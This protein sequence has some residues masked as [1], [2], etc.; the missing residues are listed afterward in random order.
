MPAV[1]T[2][3]AGGSGI[4]PTSVKAFKSGAWQTVQS[5]K[6]MSGGIWRLVWQYFT[7]SGPSIVDSLSSAGISPGARFNDN[8]TYSVKDSGGA[9]VSVGNWG[10]PTTTGQGSNYWVNLQAGS[11]SNSASAFSGPTTNTWVQ[12]SGVPTWTI[13]AAPG[14][15]NVRTRTSTYQISSSS[16]GTPVVASGSFEL[17]SDLS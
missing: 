2:V 6:V 5:I 8:G 1:T 17:T 15:P 11:T 12:I 16:G 13:S 10:S 9:Y 4:V 7:V 3:R 14:A